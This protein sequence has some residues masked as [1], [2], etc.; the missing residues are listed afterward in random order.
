[1]TKISDPA[2]VPPMP[3]AVQPLFAG[4]WIVNSTSPLSSLDVLCGILTLT[5]K[6]PVASENVA[7]AQ[8]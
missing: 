6:R 8:T 2:M 1:M 5:E 7:C 3:T 4:A